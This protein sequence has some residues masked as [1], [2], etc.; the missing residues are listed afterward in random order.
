M[1]AVSP[2][3]FEG[4]HLFV[5]S[6]V[7]LVADPAR[8]THRMDRED[9]VALTGPGCYFCLQLWRPDLGAQCAGPEGGTS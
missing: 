5:V 9:L 2:L 4:R 6:G 8:T 1:N 3:V 7:F